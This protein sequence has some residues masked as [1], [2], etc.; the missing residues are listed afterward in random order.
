VFTREELMNH[1]WK[2][3]FYGDLHATGMDGVHF[4]TESK[5]VTTRWPKPAKG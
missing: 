5:V 3:S 4:F 2:G 1:L